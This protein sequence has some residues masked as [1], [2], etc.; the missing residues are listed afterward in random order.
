MR[1][2][3]H[4]LAK[5]DL[6]VKEELGLTD[7]SHLAIAGILSLL[8]K[9]PEKRRLNSMT[10]TPIRLATPE[11]RNTMP[12]KRKMAAAARLNRTRKRVNLRKLGHA[13]MR[14]V[15]GYTMIPR[16]MGGSRRRGMMSKMTLAAK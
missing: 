11:L 5:M 6:C 3:N 7:C 14:P 12:M 10:S 1:A 15:M 8:R 13:G 4:I 16:M 9:K 2:G